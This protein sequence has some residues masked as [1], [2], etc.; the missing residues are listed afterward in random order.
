MK[1]EARTRDGPS[2][3]RQV[4]QACASKGLQLTT[5]RANV[6]QILA[7]SEAPLGAYAIIE[8]LSRRE[9]KPIAPPTVYRALEFLQDNGFL[10]KIESRNLY[11][12]CD[13]VGH[14][15]DVVLLLCETCGRSEEAE[16]FAFDAALAALA[17]KAGFSTRH[18]TMEVQGVCKRCAKAA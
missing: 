16:D 18:R 5:V 2:W 15:H 11:A 9:G 6:L 10:H 1:A 8:A 13:H 17:K 3:A 7:E 14:A 4:A 12:P